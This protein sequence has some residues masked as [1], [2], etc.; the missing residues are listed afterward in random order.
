MLTPR[1]PKTKL[2]SPKNTLSAR[3]TDREVSR[4]EWLCDKLNMTRTELVRA[5]LNQEYEDQADY[6]P[7][8]L[9]DT[10]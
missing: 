5:L 9:P 10:T 7:D 3:L 8:A 1:E 2:P 6:L 4:L